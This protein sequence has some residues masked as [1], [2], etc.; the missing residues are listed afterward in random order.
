MPY[1]FGT[2][3]ILR[4]L[5]RAMNSLR[6]N[7]EEGHQG[8]GK[9]G[10]LFVDFCMP[11]LDLLAAE[12]RLNIYLFIFVCCQGKAKLAACRQW[13]IVRVKGQL[14][15]VVSF[16]PACGSWESNSGL[17]SG[18]LASTPTDPLLV[19]GIVF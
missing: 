2:K 7:R 14:R 4:I 3:F 6:N 13:S 5:L 16:I 17:D 1:I 12:Q 9:F 8:W 11:P 19:P 10:M 15:G 18:L